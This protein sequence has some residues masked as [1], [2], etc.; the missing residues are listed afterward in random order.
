MTRTSRFTWILLGLLAIAL[1]SGDLWAQRGPGFGR[2]RGMGPG[3]RGPGGP[4]QGGDPQFIA[5]RDVFH[6]LL[7]NHD[8]IRRKVKNIDNG[9]ETVTE[10]DNPEV[11]AKIQEH[12]LGMYERV[13]DVRPIHMRDPLFAEIFRHADK[14][15]MQ[16]KNTKK[17]VRVT[18]TSDDPYVAKL[19]QAHAG[20]VSLF[21]KNGFTE[22]HVNH[23]VPEADGA[24]GTPVA[25]EAT[26]HAPAAA[27]CKNCPLGEKCPG[28]AQCPSGEKCPN[29]AACPNGEK[30]PAGEKCPNAANCPAGEKCPAAGCPNAAKCPNAATCPDGKKCPLSDVCPLGEKC[31]GGDKCPLEK[32]Q[33]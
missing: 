14:I 30:C 9:V 24:D 1:T 11:A 23:A 33:S 27:A 8:Q 20:V 29:A 32:K 5:D 16:H 31:P 4:G 2:G 6:Y 3:G 13:K 10:S 28:G 7:A 12:V 26:G 22:A 19:I 17:G 15:Q 21:V 18:E 25:A